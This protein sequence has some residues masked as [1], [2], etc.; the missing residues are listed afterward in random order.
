M[1]SSQGSL[2][3]FI[4]LGRGMRKPNEEEWGQLCLGFLDGF[5][6]ICQ[7]S[8]ENRIAFDPALVELMFWLWSQTVCGQI[9]E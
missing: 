1:P 7:L 9:N 8:A 4:P 6:C 3:W 5:P 2:T